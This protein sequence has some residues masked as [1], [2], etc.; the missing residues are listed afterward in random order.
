MKNTREDKEQQQQQQQQ[1]GAT[2]C[3]HIHTC[4]AHLKD[5]SLVG[6]KEKSESVEMLRLGSRVCLWCDFLLLDLGLWGLPHLFVDLVFIEIEGYHPVG[7]FVHTLPSC[8]CVCVFFFLVIP[9]FRTSSL[10]LLPTN[11]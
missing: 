7:T 3:A 11:S 8:V 4:R 2:S 5:R 10:S 6:K 9:F 1:Q